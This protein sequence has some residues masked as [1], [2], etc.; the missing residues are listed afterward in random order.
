MTDQALET[1]EVAEE[2]QGV[3][4]TN[5]L[6]TLLHLGQTLNVSLD[7]T[8]VLHIAIEQVVRFVNAERGF[9]LLVEEGTN[10]VWGKATHGID[11]LELESVLSGRDPKNRP[12]VSRTIIEQSL[13]DR[14]LVLS[15]NAMEDPRFAAHTSVQLSQVRSVLCVPLIAQG[16]TLGIVYLD[17]R[18]KSG[19]FTDHHAEM[20]TAFANQAAVAIQNARLYDNLRKSLEE[21]LHLQEELHDKET[22]RMALEEANRLKSD[23]IGYVSHELRNPLTTIRGYIQTLEADTEGSLGDDVKAEFYQTIEAEADRML[24]MINELLDSSRLEAGRPLTINPR[25]IDITPLLQRMARAKR[26]HKAW[27]PNHRMQAEIADNLPEIEADE[28]KV[29]Q[30]LSNLLSNAIKYSPEGGTI[31]LAARPVESGIEIVVK[32]QGVGMNEE[33]CTRLFGRFERLER[34]DIRQISGTGL[35]LYLTRKLV[36]LHGGTIK[37][38]SKPGEGSVFT[39]FLPQRLPEAVEEASE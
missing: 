18:I 23:F 22:Q 32:D 27:T 38:D 33:Q 19:V 31:T 6:R 14:R 10:R 37:C 30:I 4:T 11:P 7:L 34:D 13:K 26:F 29:L 35:G 16:Q 25:P 1:V 36:E 28:D 9:I 15:T 20:V 5:Y 24:T 2:P 17:N 21:R 39:V 3:E 12:Q 8:Q